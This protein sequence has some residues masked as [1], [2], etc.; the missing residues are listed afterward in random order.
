M[1]SLK[2]KLIFFIEIFLFLSPKKK[3]KRNQ[4]IRPFVVGC[5]SIEGTMAS[6]FIGPFH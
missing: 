1:V 6:L 3:K 2:K 4:T 5:K